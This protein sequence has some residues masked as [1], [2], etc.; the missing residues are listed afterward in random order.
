[1]CFKMLTG[2]YCAYSCVS[3]G[4]EN[5]YDGVKIITNGLS[6]V[7]SDWAKLL[8]GLVPASTNAIFYFVS[9]YECDESIA[10]MARN[11]KANL[12]NVVKV[13]AMLVFL[14]LAASGYYTVAQG[15]VTDP[16]LEGLQPNSGMG[17]ILPFFFAFAVFLTGVNNTDIIFK[18]ENKVED[19]DELTMWLQRKKLSKPKMS[20]FKNHQFFRPRIEAPVEIPLVDIVIQPSHD[21]SLP[22]LSS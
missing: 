21:E 8:I 13:I 2:L 22:R 9:G 18:Q 17:V 3:V 5:G 12:M 6:D 1:M 20:E 11:I 14:A 16:N 15:V 7:L 19:V 4:I 10:A